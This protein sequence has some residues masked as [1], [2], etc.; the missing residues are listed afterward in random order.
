M[1]GYIGVG[2]KGKGG[3]RYVFIEKNATERRDGNTKN[4]IVWRIRVYAR[5]NAELNMK[6]KILCKRGSKL[7]E[8]LTII[9]FL[10]L[11]FNSCTTA[12]FHDAAFL[13]C[14]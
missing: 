4:N 9:F 7:E 5:G 1:K 6:I 10:F 3:E 13:V 8:S 2:G 11:L 12:G 14:S